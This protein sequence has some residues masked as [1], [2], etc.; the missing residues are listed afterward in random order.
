MLVSVRV[1]ANSS[2]EKVAEDAS[3]VTVWVREKPLEG[4]ANEA[5]RGLLAAHFGVKRSAVRLVSG[6]SSRT[7]RFEISRA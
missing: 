5:V 3:G 1:K 4:K 2:L 6:A 7:K